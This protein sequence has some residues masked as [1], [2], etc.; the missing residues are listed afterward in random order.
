MENPTKCPRCHSDEALPIAYGLPGPELVEEAAAGRVALGG[1]MVWT[2]APDWRCVRC[3]HE[4][5]DDAPP[6]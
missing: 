4:W 2:E 6:S 3:G 1:Y 5:R